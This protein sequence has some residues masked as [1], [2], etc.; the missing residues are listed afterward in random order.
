MGRVISVAVGAVGGD[1]VSLGSKGL[2]VLHLT[3]CIQEEI[4]DKVW[5]A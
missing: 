5:P 4:N 2:S 1:A 3:D